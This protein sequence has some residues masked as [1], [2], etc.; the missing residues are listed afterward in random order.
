MGMVREN[1]TI[2]YPLDFKWQRS[3]RPQGSYH[4]TVVL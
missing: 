1:D 4:G 3:H 2:Y